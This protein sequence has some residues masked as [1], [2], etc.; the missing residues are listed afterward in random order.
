MIDK[1]TSSS[2][3]SSIFDVAT[4]IEVCR[5]QED[6]LD[7][8]EQLAM[9]AKQWALLVQIKV[10]NRKDPA[11]A[12]DIIEKQIANLKEKV[13]CLQ[14]YAPKLFKAIKAENDVER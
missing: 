10:E 11:M 3:S 12:L 2:Q 9:K 7:Q 5:Q 8:A 4:A 1:S 14:M 6:T 13:E